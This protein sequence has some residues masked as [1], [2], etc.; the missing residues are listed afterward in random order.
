MA[1]EEADPECVGISV[2]T[3]YMLFYANDGLL[4]PP[5]I[6]RLQED[7]DVLTGLFEQVGLRKIWTRRWTL[8]ASRVAQKANTMILHM[9]GGELLRDHNTE[10]DRGIGSDSINAQRTWCL[11]PWWRTTIPST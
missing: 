2:Q 5:R 8:H 9:S 7:L 11:G 4:I 3:L 10:P 6:D 1:G